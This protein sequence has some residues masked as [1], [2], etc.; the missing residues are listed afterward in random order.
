MPSFDIYFL[1]VWFLAYAF[2]NVYAGSALTLIEEKTTI[3]PIVKFRAE[4]YTI[5][6]LFA[7]L[8]FII[9][10]LGMNWLFDQFKAL[11]AI[12]FGFQKSHLFKKNSAIGVVD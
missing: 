9:L 12:I 3:T 1:C 2:S 6:P 5:L 10:H 7:I 8:K 4:I 11:L